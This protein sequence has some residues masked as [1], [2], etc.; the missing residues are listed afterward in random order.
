MAADMSTLKRRIA[1]AHSEEIVSTGLAT[2]LAHT[3]PMTI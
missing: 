1:G 2:Q 3:I